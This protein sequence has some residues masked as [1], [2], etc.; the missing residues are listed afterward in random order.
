MMKRRFSKH[1]GQEQGPGMNGAP[2]RQPL[3]LL[4]SIFHGWKDLPNTGI[5]CLF[6]RNQQFC[7]N[8]SL[9]VSN[10]EIWFTSVIRDCMTTLEQIYSL[11]FY[12]LGEV[13]SPRSVW[14]G[15]LLCWQGLHFDQRII[16]KQLSCV[17][18]SGWLD[19]Y[20]P[21]SKPR[22][23]VHDFTSQWH[24]W[25]HLGLLQ[26]N[27]TISYRDQCQTFDTFCGLPN[28]IG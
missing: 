11:L 19:K 10:R 15:H 28:A 21:W 27:K 4:V 16:D 5:L 17:S 9:H 3:A 24:T 1:S 14:R 2:F 22:F 18:R 8:C 20:C 25:Y 12:Y 6:K 23:V 7:P 13:S 26:W